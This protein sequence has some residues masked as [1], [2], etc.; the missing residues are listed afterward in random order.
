MD[1][2]SYGRETALL[3]EIGRLLRSVAQEQ[4]TDAERGIL[5]RAITACTVLDSPEA[6]AQ[7]LREA[8]RF[9]LFHAVSGQL[10]EVLNRM[11]E[12]LVREM[13]ESEARKSAGD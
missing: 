9:C 13:H 7:A 5:Q 3:R 12:E 10:N 4:M 6:S 2:M 1:L 8:G 11:E